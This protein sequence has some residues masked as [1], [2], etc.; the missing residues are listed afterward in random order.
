MSETH[1][2]N[3]DDFDEI[4]KNGKKVPR[5][6]AYFME[7]RE[8]IGPKAFE[9]LKE[10]VLEKKAK[11]DQYSVWQRTKIVSRFNQDL[12]D[13]LALIQD[14]AFLILSRSL[15]FFI[16]AINIT[17]LFDSIP[18]RDEFM[19]NKALK[20]LMWKNEFNTHML[21]E[22]SGAKFDKLKSNLFNLYNDLQ[23]YEVMKSQ[24]SL[25]NDWLDQDHL[26]E[27]AVQLDFQTFSKMIADLEGG[28]QKQDLQVAHLDVLLF[29]SLLEHQDTVT[30]DAILSNDT[31]HWLA[32]ELLTHIQNQCNYFL[33]L[34]SEKTQL[35]QNWQDVQKLEIA[36]IEQTQTDL[37][38]AVKT[39]KNFVKFYSLSSAKRSSVKKFNFT[40]HLDL[41]NQEHVA[42]RMAAWHSV[43]L[44]RVKKAIRAM[45]PRKE[46]EKSISLWQFI[47]S[48]N[49][50]E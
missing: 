50:N 35:G 14:E 43:E 25:L 42:T 21:E 16:L 41:S 19:E 9:E 23:L 40:S 5:S 49:F 27:K 1:Y 44:K 4:E 26:V 13:E 22:T 37:Y 46:D 10:K 17:T 47:L 15:E 30:V 6:F 33:Q 24:G 7:L 29:K 38:E 3:F 48:N 39:C 12:E 45:K 8:I 31:C 20:F 36:K 34:Q 11:F 32:P 2:F 28:A 18:D